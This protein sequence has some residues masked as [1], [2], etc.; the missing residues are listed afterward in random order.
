MTITKNLSALDRLNRK[1]FEHEETFDMSNWVDA[2][3]GVNQMLLDGDVDT[4]KLGEC[5]TTACAAGHAINDFV[6]PVEIRRNERS[7]FG[8]TPEIFIDGMPSD[9]FF[10]REVREHADFYREYYQDTAGMALDCSFTDSFPAIEFAE[11]GARV[12]G[13]TYPEA[14]T[15]FYTGKE[16]AKHLIS[17][18]ISIAY[19]E[20]AV[21]HRK[22]EAEKFGEWTAE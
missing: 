3:R 19:W 5:G 11:V 8:P 22:T 13:L 10:Y 1:I 17:G 9:D 21:R 7:M 4:V 20:Q 15:V 16:R 6:G 12:L 18:F 2:E 14:E